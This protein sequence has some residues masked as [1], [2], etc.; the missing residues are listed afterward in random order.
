MEHKKG[1]SRSSTQL[2]KPSPSIFSTIPNLNKDLVRIYDS[3]SGE[4]KIRD[5]NDNKKIAPLIDSVGRWR[6][7]LGLKEE[8]SKEE[9]IINVNFIRE[10]FA[11][12]SVS[13]IDRAIQM[14]V[15]GK[16]DV[17]N[18]CYGK[19]SPLYISKILNAYSLHR[20]N[21][22]QEVKLKLQKLEQDKPKVIDKNELAKS[23][24]ALFMSMHESSLKGEQYDDFGGVWYNKIRKY[25]WF[26][27][28]KDLAQQAYNYGM[29][30]ISFEATQGSLR[31]VTLGEV[32]SLDDKK[33]KA[34]VYARSYIVNKWLLS[35]PDARVYAKKMFTKET[36]IE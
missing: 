19:F 29:K 20:N 6:F 13:D 23:M 11:S 17:D 22:I 31:R 21:A 8:P 5:L 28:S 4:P 15:A 33:E 7:Y 35:I 2:T 18:E 25:K 34:K 24:Y 10:H 9:I 14:S 26:E 3:Y 32:M 16:L 1:L 36:L 12:L 30:R 27:I